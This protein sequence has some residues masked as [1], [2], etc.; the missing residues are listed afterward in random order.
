MAAPG[1][2]EEEFIER[3]PPSS[4]KLLHLC[5]LREKSRFLTDGFHVSGR[6]NIYC[7]RKWRSESRPRRKR[8]GR[9]KLVNSDAWVFKTIYQECERNQEGKN[10]N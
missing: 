4:H 9:E 6:E 10:G 3:E 8:D 1:E 7:C 5:T 2:E